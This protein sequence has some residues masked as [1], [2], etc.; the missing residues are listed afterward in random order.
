MLLEA[1]SAGPTTY[2][3]WIIDR[4]SVT[5]GSLNT[6]VVFVLIDLLSFLFRIWINDLTAL[7]HFERVSTSSDNGSQCSSQEFEDF[8]KD[9]E[10]RHKLNMVLST[11]APLLNADNTKDIENWRKDNASKTILLRPTFRTY[12]SVCRSPTRRLVSNR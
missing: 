1:L 9:Y 11:T 3:L 8:I 10:F 2:L 7:T 5:P 6:Y 4:V 12:R